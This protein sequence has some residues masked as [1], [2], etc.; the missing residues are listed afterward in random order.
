MPIQHAQA[1]HPTAEKGWRECL[2]CRALVPSTATTQPC[3][4]TNLVHEPFDRDDHR[5]VR[6]VPSDPGEHQWKV[7]SKCRMLFFGPN[8]FKSVCPADGATHNGSASPD[9]S[10]ALNVPDLVGHND[11]RRCFQC[12]SLFFNP[13][14]STSVCPAGG[15]HLPGLDTYTLIADWAHPTMMTEGHFINGGNTNF[16]QGGNTPWPA[17]SVTPRLRRYD[18]TETSVQIQVHPFSPGDTEI[19]VEWLN[20]SD[21]WVD[22][23][24]AGTERG[25]E[26]QP[27]NTFNEGITGVG[28]GGTLRIK[29][30]NSPESARVTKPMKIRAEGGPATIGR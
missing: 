4:S 17:G 27:Y 23:N 29:P 8:G 20:E 10:L 9:Y 15:I 19:T 28:R 14:Q 3:P 26:L 18:G 16:L 22:F 6:D 5:L 13:R 1:A 12:E 25:T 11:W 2:Q 21:T 24:Y 7:C 30:G